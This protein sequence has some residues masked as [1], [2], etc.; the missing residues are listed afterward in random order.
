MSVRLKVIEMLGVKDGQIPII[1]GLDLGQSQD[2]TAAAFVERIGHTPAYYKVPHLLRWPLKTSYQTIAEDVR[3]LTERDEVA[4]QRI[5]NCETA[6]RPVALVVDKTGVGAPVVDMLKRLSLRPH[7][8]V[9]TG[10]HEVTKVHMGESRVPKVH[11]VNSVQLL[12]N[13]GRLKISPELP[14]SK[15]LDDELH[16]FQI[17]KTGTGAAQYEAPWREGE[18]DDLVLAVAL[19]VWYGEN[20]VYRKKDRK[21]G[22]IEPPHYRGD[23][24]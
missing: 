12:L 1:V 14:E 8:V 9:I 17:R 21:R 4:I 13:D 18:H 3:D 11:L 24:H 2:Y 22:P 7:A 10:G 19:A 16:K 23:I 5:S 6:S 20:K 15:Q